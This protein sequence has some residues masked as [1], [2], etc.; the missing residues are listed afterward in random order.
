MTIYLENGTHDD[1]KMGGDRPFGFVF[2]GIFT[3]LVLTAYIKDLSAYII[4]LIVTSGAFFLA[5]LF[6]PFLLRPLNILWFRFGLL[7][8]KII[9]PIVLGGLF[10]VSVTPI[11]LFMR[12]LGKDPLKLRLDPDA[13]S[14]WI[15]RD[16]PGPAANSMSDQF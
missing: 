12:V 15:N 13:K 1:T 6:A 7:L 10:I 5:S 14:Y 2:T 4:P 9:S 11:G 8:H 3:I 16:P